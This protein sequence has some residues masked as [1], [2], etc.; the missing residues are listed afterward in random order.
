MTTTIVLNPA[1]GRGH[2]ARLRDEVHAQ[3]ALHW[4]DVEL[5][6]TR[7]PREATALVRQAVERGATRVVAVGGDGTVH[8]AA[9]GI[10][11][12]QVERLPPLAVIPAGTGN[13]Y[14]K[15]VGTHR[16]GPKQA[17]ARI[18]RGQVR[19]LDVGRAWDEYFLNAIGIG[20]DVE[21]AR[22]VNGFRRLSG[23]TAYLVAVLQAYASFKPVHLHVTA[24]AHT[25][26]EPLLLLEMGIGPTVG[27]GFRL[28][29]NAV[30]D[31]GLLDICAIRRLSILGFATKLPLAMLGKH[32]HLKQVASFQ[33]RQVIIERSDGPLLAQA[34]GE[35]RTGPARL[36]IRLE[37]QRLPVIVAAARPSAQWAQ[38]G[39][40]AVEATPTE[41]RV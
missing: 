8:E 14:A 15:L 36:E 11:T 23:P 37:A 31:D 13:D 25:L 16:L 21:V 40:D 22:R 9:N 41:G 18:V 28:T 27:G 30:P 26:D 3:A 24:D 10:L 38:P 33:T 2:A 17:L 19:W 32:T 4:R 29:P 6:E 35:L 20:F 39:G 34:D 12:A 1:A 7:A 5:I